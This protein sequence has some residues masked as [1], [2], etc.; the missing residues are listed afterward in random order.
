[1]TTEKDNRYED[2]AHQALE[3]DTH[4]LTTVT[5]MAD[6]KAVVAEENIYATSGTLLL[7]K[8]IPLGSNLREHLLKHKL[9]KPI[10]LSL[11]VEDGVTAEYLAQEAALLLEGDDYL[12]QLSNRLVDASELLHGFSRVS[13]P[14]QIAFKLTVAR[15]QRPQL[16]HHL[17]TVALIG[18]YLALRLA[19]PERERGDALLSALIHDLGELHTEPALLD[20]QHPLTD[21]ERRYIYVHPITGYLIAREAVGIHA[22]I[23]VA[24]L[25][26]QERLDGSGYPYGLR[27]ERIGT[28][29]RIIGVADVCASILSRF[30]N[31]QRLSILMRLNHRK[32][33]PRLLTMLQEGFTPQTDTSSA[34]DIAALPKLKAAAQL[35][36]RWSE[37]RASL[38][39]LSG[40]PYQELDFLFERM[41]NL[42]TLLLQ[43]GFDPDSLQLL[44]ELAGEDPKMASEL[45]AALDEIHW[46]FNDLE[47]EISRHRET[48]EAVLSAE[49][50]A[51]LD[52]WIKELQG[53][54]GAHQ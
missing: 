50:N 35:L 23:P 53:Y 25:Q 46:Q 44:A 22:T 21:E 10:D 36:E 16:F 51:I 2:L 9:L 11:S 15:E 47:R 52:R 8:G 27:A 33:D 1:M 49:G 19:L 48:I 29:A 45:A 37:F 39:G 7:A 41:V 3:E 43:F 38:P 34:T 17:L 6:R 40:A 54:L 26:H 4:Y 18:H 32:Y 14:P 28:L 31:N 5:E 30:G 24:V 42:R 12:R 13:L 20:S